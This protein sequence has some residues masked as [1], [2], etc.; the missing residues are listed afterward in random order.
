M[1]GMLAMSKAGHDKEA[2]YVVVR[3][4]KEYVYVADG[5]L[6][7]M[8]N[9]KKKN[10]KHIQIVKKVVDDELKNR[11]I[12]GQNVRNEEVKRMI[13]EQYARAKEVLTLHKEGHNQLAQLLIEKEVIFAEDVERIF[14]KR[15]W[16]SRSEEIMNQKEQK[17]LPE[18]NKS[19]DTPL[20]EDKEA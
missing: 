13:N 17:I 2:V 19:E 10:K 14:G 5:R 6:K 4:E 7:T 12:S 1:V 15:P 18:E 3:E 16:A 8:E 9:P 20:L 11:L